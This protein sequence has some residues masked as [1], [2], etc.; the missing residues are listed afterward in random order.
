MGLAAARCCELPGQAVPPQFVGRDVERLRVG[1]KSGTESTEFA[2][3]ITSIPRHK[4]TPEQLLARN[5]GH[6]AWKKIDAQETPTSKRTP[7][8]LAVI[9][10]NISH[11]TGGTP[12]GPCS[13]PAEPPS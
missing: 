12:S 4:G 5:W 10:G 8:A 9:L 6:W 11:D 2:C 13:P 3:C 7:A 1:L